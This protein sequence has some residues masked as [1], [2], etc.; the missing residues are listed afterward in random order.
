MLKLADADLIIAG[1]LAEGRKLNLLPLTVA[2]LDRG[3]HLV[4]GKREDDSGFLRFGIAMAKAWGSLGMGY[5]SRELMNRA[6]KQP[7]FFSMLSD[8]SQGRIAASP[9]GVLIL[10]NGQVIG[11]V[12][13][14]GDTGPHDE[15]CALAGINAAGL[16]ARQTS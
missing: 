1:A 3:G 6:E 15:I 4:A 5:D 10:R 7:A 16:H 2:V 14:S 13:I 9:G 11:A 12:G 8:I